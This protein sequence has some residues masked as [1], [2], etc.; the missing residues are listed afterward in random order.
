MNE[1]KNEE[2]YSYTYSARQR[3]EIEEIRKKYLPEEADKMAQV[4]RL[5]AGVTRKGTLIAVTIGFVS[6]LLMGVGM[7]CTM[8]WMDRWFIPGVIVGL[9]GIFGMAAA[10]PIFVK[11]TKRERERIAPQIL[12]LTEELMK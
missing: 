1:I 11:V 7:C 6:C 2:S 9:I 3:Q 8:L 12:K 5:D 10:Y 4:R